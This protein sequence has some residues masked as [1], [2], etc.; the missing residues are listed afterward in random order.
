MKKA[1]ITKLQQLNWRGWKLN[2]RTQRPYI[3]RDTYILRTQCAY[4]HIWWQAQ[5]CVKWTKI[6][7]AVCRHRVKGKINK[8][9]IWRCSQISPIPLS[10]FQSHW[11]CIFDTIKM[12]SISIEHPKSQWQASLF[13]SS[14]F[15]T[16]CCD[17][18]LWK[19]IFLW[20]SKLNWC[21][22]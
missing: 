14:F 12:H 8:F 6:C 13:S 22:P 7:V 9:L 4:D 16:F 17:K 2:I 11:K 20:P 21:D 15:C 10:P 3:Q 19:P 1:K 18:L 5:K